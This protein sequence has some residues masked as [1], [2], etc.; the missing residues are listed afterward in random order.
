[1]GI[2]IRPYKKSDFNSVSKLFDD[3]Q[4]FIVEIDDLKRCLRPDGYGNLYTNLILKRIRKTNGFIFI[5]EANKKITG[6]IAGEIEKLKT[7]DILGCVPTKSG[8]ILELFIDEKE[9]GKGLGSSLMKKAEDYFRS[10]G[11]DLVRL[12]VFSPNKRT[13]TF[14]LKQKYAD[15]VIDMIKILG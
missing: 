4:N 8:R 14:Y 13:H 6:L 2:R 1:M 7:E 11:C 9:R 3:F 5:A 15:R 10:T 12:D